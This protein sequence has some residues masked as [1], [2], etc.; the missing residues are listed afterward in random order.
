MAPS[1]TGQKSRYVPF[2]SLLI[3]LAFLALL[4]CLVGTYVYYVAA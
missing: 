4:S 3:L 2:F 1:M